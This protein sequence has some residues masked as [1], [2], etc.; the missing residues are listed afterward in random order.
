MGN[1][2][3]DDGPE[4]VRLDSRDCADPS[5]AD[6]LCSL[7]SVKQQQFD[8]YVNDVLTKRTKSVR[9]TIKKNNLPLLRT[10]LVKR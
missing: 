6:A 1:P 8:K 7:E 5:V 3:L 4:L 2:F 10:S 9:D